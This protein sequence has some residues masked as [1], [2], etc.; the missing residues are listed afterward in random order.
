MGERPVSK[1]LVSLF[2]LEGAP[3]ATVD[4][5]RHEIA[6][7]IIELRDSLSLQLFDLHYGELPSDKAT[8]IRA[9]IPTSVYYST[10][11]R[12]CKIVCYDE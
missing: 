10:I 2:T 9:A 6:A 5:V 3:E 12:Y 7:A 8:A 4:S 1:G 11:N